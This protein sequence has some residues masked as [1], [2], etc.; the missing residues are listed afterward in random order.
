MSNS[1]RD[2]FDL[3]AE[4]MTYHADKKIALGR[5]REEC[6]SL[7]RQLEQAEE[8]ADALS[9]QVV[10]HKAEIVRYARELLAAK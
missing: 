2:A 8:R 9:R 1:N 3:L 10:V 7:K 6:A 4:A 5:A